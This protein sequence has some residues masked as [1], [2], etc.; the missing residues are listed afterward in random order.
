MTCGSVQGWPVTCIF[1][2]YQES[3]SSRIME[4]LK[5]MVPWY[6]AI[7]CRSQLYT[8]SVLEMVVGDVIQVR[9]GDHIQGDT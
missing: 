3:K 7:I 9:F 2:N 4:L 8:K 5:N 6:V 1:S